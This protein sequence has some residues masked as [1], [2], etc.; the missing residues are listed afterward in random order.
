MLHG[1]ISPSLKEKIENDIK[2][3]FEITSDILN[4]IDW[5]SKNNE[6]LIYALLNKSFTFETPFPSLKDDTFGSSQST[7]RYFGLDSTA[8]DKTFNQVTAL[9]YNSESDFAIKINTIENDELILYRTDNISNFQNTYL[10]LEQKANSY[11]GNKK[12]LRETD[13]LKI[14]YVNVHSMINYD[15]L[16]KKI[17][18][19]SNGSYINYALQIINF[20]L[21]NYGGNL[22]SEA[23]I[24][25]YISDSTAI[26][27]DFN[28]TNRFIIYIKEKDK[29]IPY[30]ALLIDTTD[31]LL[32]NK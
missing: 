29:N 7:V 31:V 26:T 24:D 30:F 9:F 17:L 15:D 5:N 3:K 2:I 12:L 21:N 27:R 1:I 19:N 6:Y 14:P 4:N 13:T 20:S 32:E 8:I 11:S 25:T 23:Y 18:K 16:C 10:E 28:F 22:K